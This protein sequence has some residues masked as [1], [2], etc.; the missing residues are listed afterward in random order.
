MNSCLSKLVVSSSLLSAVAIITSIAHA[1]DPNVSRQFQRQ[2]GCPATQQNHGACPGWQ[3]DHIVPLCAG[4]TDTISNLQ[5]LTVEQHRWKTR[6][7]VHNCRQKC[8]PDIL[9]FDGSMFYSV[10]R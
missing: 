8:T 6:I 7:D 2:H 10:C 3:K 5:W 9:Y 4:G 1:R